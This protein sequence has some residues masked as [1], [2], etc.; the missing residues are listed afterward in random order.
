MYLAT[1]SAIVM[2]VG[3]LVRKTASATIITF[4]IVFGDFMLSGYLRDSSSAFLRMIS[5]NTLMTQI[6]K[7][8]GVYVVN[9]QQIVLSGINDYIRATLIPIII[10]ICLIVTLIS[11][12]KR[13]IHTY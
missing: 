3:M 9:S 7:F 6:L 1:Y 10:A 2:M 12:K 5:D 11:F 13:D 8:S 4:V